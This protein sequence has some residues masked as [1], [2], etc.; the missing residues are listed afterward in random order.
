MAPLKFEE[1]MKEQLEERKISPSAKNWEILNAKLN[2]A[3]GQKTKSNKRTFVTIAAS[4]LL[5][6]GLLPF[7]H[8]FNNKKTNVIVF[9]NTNTEENIIDKELKLEEV[10][11]QKSVASVKVK[12]EE[13]KEEEERELVVQNSKTQSVK[14]NKPKA[15]SLAKNSV[16]LT[17]SKKIEKPQNIKVESEQ[18]LFEQSI[19]K[20]AA[21][22]LAQIHEKESLN[23]EVTEAEIDEL[24]KKAQW[25]I[26]QSQQLKHQKSIDAMALLNEVETELDENFRERVFDALKTSLYKLKTAVA[27]RDN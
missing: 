24:L 7:V 17:T 1:Y 11:D 8:N 18:S 22:L 15:E 10:L 9:S 14:I 2:A 26:T 13:Q 20:K 21:D 25:E 3:N 4:V 23:I 6:L 5:L 19:E 27:Q 16:Q 12:E